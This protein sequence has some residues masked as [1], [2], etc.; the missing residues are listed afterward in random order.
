MNSM[1]IRRSEAGLP[2]VGPDWH[3]AA[4]LLAGLKR[5]VL[6]CGGFGSGKTEVAVNFALGLRHTGRPVAIA[7]LDI[8]NPYFR[9]REVRAQLAAEGIRVIVPGGE[10][11]SAD[12]PIVQPEIRGA[13]GSSQG[14]VVLDLGG[15]PVG[16]RVL[17][18]MSDVMPAGG[19]DGLFVLNSR[20][21]ATRTAE[22]TIRMMTAISRTASV[23]LDGL[24]V[25][26]HLIEETGPEVVDEGITL[27]EQVSARTGARVAFVVVERRLL[28]DFDPAACGY[29]VMVIDRLMLKPW[30][31]TN[32]LG[33][34]R[35]GV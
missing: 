26:S 35:I 34:Y 17:A 23:S 18:S 8:V 28:A 27:A 16:A 24:V 31:P 14:S 9:S 6:F 19:V 3:N 15:D 30:E 5:V 33:K 1:S 4:G 2:Q 13:L 29:P 22:A 7:D 20:R 25:N 10:L 21:P 12:L 32:W 11:A